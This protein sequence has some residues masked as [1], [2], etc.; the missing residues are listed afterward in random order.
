MHIASPVVKAC[1]A[2]GSERTKICES[3]PLLIMLTRRRKYRCID[4]GRPFRAADRRRYRRDS[5]NQAVNYKR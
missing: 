4:C 5:R 1:P 3:S 2:C